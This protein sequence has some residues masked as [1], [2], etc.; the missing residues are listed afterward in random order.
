MAPPTIQKYEFLLGPAGLFDMAEILDPN[1]L[2]IDISE[3]TELESKAR[4]GKRVRRIQ[5]K[6][7]SQD[8]H[9]FLWNHRAR[10]Y[11]PTD[12]R[13]DGYVGI[14]GTCCEFEVPG[15]ERKRIPGTELDTEAEYAEGTAIDLRILMM[16]FSTPG[17]EINGMFNSG[18]Y[19][20]ILLQKEKFRKSS[21]RKLD[22]VK[23][24]FHYP[25]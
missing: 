22:C 6:F 12:Y 3:D 17:E 15:H 5:L 24:R 9:G 13:G 10:I 11:V 16:F 18:N 20:V 19:R 1:T 7:T 14:I 23:R 4:K 21:N 2:A 25:S 8:W